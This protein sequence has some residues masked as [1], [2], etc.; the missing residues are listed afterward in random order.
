V[1]NLWEPGALMAAIHGETVGT[2]VTTEK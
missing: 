2:L 1:L